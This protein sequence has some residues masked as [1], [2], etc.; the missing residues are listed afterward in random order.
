MDRHSVCIRRVL[1]HGAAIAASRTTGVAAAATTN[2]TL[3][4]QQSRAVGSRSGAINEL[5]G[6]ALN[7]R[8]AALGLSPVSDARSYMI[9]DRPWLAADPILGPWPD[10]DGEGV[11][12]TGAWIFPDERPLSRELE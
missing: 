6:A 9:T 12:Q 5:F 11:F 7:A 8:R 10:R 2:A 1:R 3:D 4:E